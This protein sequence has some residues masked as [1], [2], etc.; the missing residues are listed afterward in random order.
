MIT[1]ANIGG[2][3]YFVLIANLP[4]ADIEGIRFLCTV[5]SIHLLNTII[6]PGISVNTERSESI[7]ALI[8]TT[9]RSSPILNCMNASA[10]RP[11]TV[12]RLLDEIS[13]IAL[14]SAVM[15]ASLAGRFS[16]SSVYLWHRIIA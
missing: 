6:R 1:A 10:R 3:I 9:A 4:T 14:L 2:I 13:G 12:V 7:I 16:L 11:D 15:V 5:L 8:R